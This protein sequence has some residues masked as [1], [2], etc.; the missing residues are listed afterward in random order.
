MLLQTKLYTEDWI[1]LKTLDDAGKVKF[2]SVPGDH[3]QMAHD[4]AVKYVV[5]YLTDQ[6]MFSS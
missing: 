5:P 6:P 3:L 4:D 2:V 1:G